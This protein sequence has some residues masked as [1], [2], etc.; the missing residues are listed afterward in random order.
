MSLSNSIEALKQT[1]GTCPEAQTLIEAAQKVATGETTLA[2][3]ITD[4]LAPAECPLSPPGWK[5]TRPAGHD[6]PCAAFPVVAEV[7]TTPLSN[8]PWIGVDLDGTLAFYDKWRGIDH[9]GT[10]IEP[11][12]QR[13]LQ[14]LAEGKHVRILTARVGPQRADV[15]HTIADITHHIEQWC[16]QHLGQVLPVTCQKDYNMLELWDDRAVQI[17]PNSGRSI[18]EEYLYAGA[19]NFTLRKALQHYAGADYL[20]TDQQNLAA[21]ALATPPHPVVS[22]VQHEAAIA[23][24]NQRLI[25][26][27]TGTQAIIQQQQLELNRLRSELRQEKA[28]LEAF[29]YTFDAVP[30]PEDQPHYVPSHLLAQAVRQR[31]NASAQLE[32]MIQHHQES[33]E[34]DSIVAS[35]GCL[36]KTNDPQHHKPGCKY[37]LIME[38]NQHLDALVP[39]AILTLYEHGHITEGEACKLM[40]C[41]DIVSFRLLREEMFKT[42]C[43]LLKL[44]GTPAPLPQP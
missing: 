19:H 41:P 20:T 36:T 24:L 25:D 4:T 31:D 40:E 35:C 39:H 38:R 10:P 32:R 6:G 22:L 28:I 17:K 16:V 23:D 34:T 12:R 44:P 7:A 42:M 9:I 18:E 27:T 37:R 2:Q 30:S 1:P 14:W 11:M 15:A 26:R 8:E 33:M 5:C 43:R 3:V 21:V 13:V 29:T